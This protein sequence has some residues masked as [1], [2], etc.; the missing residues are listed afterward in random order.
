MSNISNAERQARFRKKDELK[1]YADK[2]FRECSLHR[3]TKPPQE[4]RLFLDK[5]IDLPS[6]WTNDDYEQ[7]VKTLNH[8]HLEFYDNP[9]QLANDVREGKDSKNVFMTTPDP[10]KFIAEEKDAIKKAKIL[11]S[12]LLSALELS[13]CP[14]SDQAA[15]LMEAIRFVGRSIASS[16]IVPKSQATTMCLTS[17]GPQYNRP[18]WFISSLVNTLGWNLNKDLAYE[19]GK[20]LM[21]FKYNNSSSDK[22]GAI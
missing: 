16:R 18:V 20:Q 14:D 6:G 3:M 19:V 22:E 12:H 5:T 4:I 8:F 1:R 13:G 2:I 11:S 17:I 15:A 21:E 7:A 10:S 9:H